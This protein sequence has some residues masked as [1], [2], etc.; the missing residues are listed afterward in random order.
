MSAV[1]SSALDAVGSSPKFYLVTDALAL[2]YQPHGVASIAALKKIIDRHST[3]P[4]IDAAV[5]AALSKLMNKQTLPVMAELLNSRDSTA[6]L[7]AAAFFG[8][9]TLFADRRAASQEVV[10]LGHTLPT[11]RGG[12]C[13]APARELLRS[14]IASFGCS[15]GR[16]ITGCSVSETECFGDQRYMRVEELRMSVDH[17]PRENFR[18]HAR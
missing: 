16:R 7:R 14:S 11:K 18:S 6:Q 8:L 15:G 3:A 9:F 13:R 2:S 5:G 10:R 17:C 12:S 1:L 4:G